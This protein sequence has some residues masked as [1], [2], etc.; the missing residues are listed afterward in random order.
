MSFELAKDIAQWFRLVLLDYCF[1]GKPTKF[2][3]TKHGNQTP[4]NM[5]HI[6]TEENTKLKTADKAQQFGPR[7]IRFF[8]RKEAVGICSVDSI[9]SLTRNKKQVE[10]P[11]KKTS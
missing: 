8:A 7:G 4:S 9:S 10:K 5:P 3:V 6:R 2:K 11:C 1:D